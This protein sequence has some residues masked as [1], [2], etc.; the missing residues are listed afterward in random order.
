MGE[1]SFP[2]FPIE[3]VSFGGFGVNNDFGEVDVSP[4]PARDFS[5]E[6]LGGGDLALADLREAPELVRVYQDL[7]GVVYAISAGRR[8]QFISRQNIVFSVG[9]LAVLVPSAVP[10]IIGVAA[11]VVAHEGS[12]LLAVANGLRA[13]WVR[14][15]DV[16]GG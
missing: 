8:A 12:E 3:G 13:A 10:G 9:L 16:R 11:A 6:L 1:S 5:L 15:V 14:P 2:P 4:V 7:G